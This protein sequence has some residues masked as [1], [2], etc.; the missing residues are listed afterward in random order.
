[1]SFE[2]VFSLGSNCVPAH[3]TRRLFGGRPSSC[4]DWLVTP[5]S[6]LSQIFE[7]D[8]RH[9][10]E[11]VIECLDGKSVM[12]KHYGV[13]YHHEFSHDESGKVIIDD[14]MLNNA[15]NKL[16][17][18]YYK[19][20]SIASK[21]RTLFIRYGSG[22]DAPGDTASVTDSEFLKLVDVIERKIGHANFELCYIWQQGYAFER[23]NIG[24]A[25]LPH[26]SFY[27]DKYVCGQL[28]D[29]NVWDAF[30]ISKGF[31]PSVPPMI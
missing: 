27:T 18:K 11:E 6:A 31:D 19:M 20:V 16:I 15:R 17:Y 10:G 5:F 8:G 30:F 13:L 4:F 1:M 28:G 23:A 29:D 25:S 21:H 9:F 14:H 7:D 2:A 24:S 3:Q 12:C 26:C 22:T